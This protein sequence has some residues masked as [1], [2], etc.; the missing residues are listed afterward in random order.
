MTLDKIKAVLAAKHDMASIAGLPH[1]FRQPHS[2]DTEDVMI[3]KSGAPP[4]LQDCKTAHGITAKEVFVAKKYASERDAIEFDHRWCT[5]SNSKTPGRNLIAKKV[6]VYR[7]ERNQSSRGMS[8]QHGERLLHSITSQNAE[9]VDTVIL[10]YL[11][12]DV[13][14]KVGVLA[15]TQNGS[16]EHLPLPLEVTYGSW[17]L[18]HEFVVTATVARL[19]YLCLS[20]REHV[21]HRSVTALCEVQ[22]HGEFAFAGPIRQFM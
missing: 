9:Y 5:R 16:M 7:A 8:G 11:N 12:L 3:V 21:S 1:T 15:V 6:A 20:S 14:A 17:L 10:K 4:L 13:V 19:L 2:T 18:G 22:L